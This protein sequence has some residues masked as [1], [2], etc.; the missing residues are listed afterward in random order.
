MQLNWTPSRRTQTI[1]PRT[2][3]KGYD[4]SET[5]FGKLL[6]RRIQICCVYFC[7]IHFWPLFQNNFSN[8]VRTKIGTAVDLDSPRQI[9]LSRGLRFF[10]GAS[11]CLGIDVLLVSGIQANMCALHNT[12]Q[13]FSLYASFFSLITKNP[14]RKLDLHSYNNS[15]SPKKYLS[16]KG[17]YSA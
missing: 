5:T 12:V 9:F 16:S 3:Q 14:Y 10:W 7:V 2:N 1:N 11:V 4:K 6:A 15:N 8:D 13:Y 17:R